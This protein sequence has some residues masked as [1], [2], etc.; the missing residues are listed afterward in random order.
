ML[1]TREKHLSLIHILI[2]VVDVVTDGGFE[3]VSGAASNW[4]AY[5]SGSYA[6]T[7]DEQYAGAAS[8]KVM[9]SGGGV[10]SALIRCV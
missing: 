7:T 9:G 6:I 5:N 2:D 3:D 10:R 8:C 1:F 4:F